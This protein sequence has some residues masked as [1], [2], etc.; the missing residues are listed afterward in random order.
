MVSRFVTLCRQIARLRHKVMGNSHGPNVRRM[1]GT[2][3]RGL[4]VP[5]ASQQLAADKQLAANRITRVLLSRSPAV[6]NPKT[7]T[8]CERAEKKCAQENASAGRTR[9]SSRPPTARNRIAR[10]ARFYALS[11]AGASGAD[12]ERARLAAP[13]RAPRR[14]SGPVLTRADADFSLTRTLTWFLIYRRRV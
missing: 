9:D 12:A 2:R 1:A 8:I 14:A 6:V 4:A 7:S 3:P 11:V 13:E 5:R 10:R